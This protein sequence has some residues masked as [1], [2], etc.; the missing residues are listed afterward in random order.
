MDLSA[1]GFWR[2]DQREFFNIKGYEPVI[3]S[4]PHKNLGAAHSKQESEKHRQCEN[5]IQ[6]EHAP[7]TPLVFTIMGK[8]SKCLQKFFI[9]LDEMLA[10]KKT[11]TKEHCSFVVKMQ[12][13]FF[14][15]AICSKMCTRHETQKICSH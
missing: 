3:P 13:I 5:R 2:Q 11:T 14:S 8:M 9:R 7:L 6:V 10:E 4:Q 1:L 12:G 15:P